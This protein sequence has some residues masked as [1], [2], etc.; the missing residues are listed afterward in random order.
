MGFVPE[1]HTGESTSREVAVA[2]N[3]DIAARVTTVAKATLRLAL[4]NGWAFSGA[5]SERSERPV[6]ECS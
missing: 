2:Q 3:D 1:H 5:P 4:P 6:P